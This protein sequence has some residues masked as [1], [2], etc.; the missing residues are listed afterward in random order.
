MYFE[1]GG[2]MNFSRNKWYLAENIIQ[3]SYATIIKRKD[4]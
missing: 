2:S 3:I 4:V 1:T